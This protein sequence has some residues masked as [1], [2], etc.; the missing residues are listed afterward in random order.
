MLGLQVGGH[1]DGLVGSFVQDLPEWK[2][3]VH[4]QGTQSSGMPGEWSKEG[5]EEAPNPQQLSPFEKLLVLKVRTGRARLP[6]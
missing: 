1:F 5:T 3:W 2:E 6:K 4:T